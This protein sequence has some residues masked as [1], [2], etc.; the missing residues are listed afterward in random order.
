MKFLPTRAMSAWRSYF[1]T[2][3]AVISLLSKNEAIFIIKDFP[4][5]DLAHV[6]SVQGWNE[7][8][9]NTCKYTNVKSS[10]TKCQCY[11]DPVTELLFTFEQ[12]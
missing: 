10:V 6:K 7:Q 2:G 12:K 4:D 5:Y 11:K 9:L 8:F 1:D 3:E